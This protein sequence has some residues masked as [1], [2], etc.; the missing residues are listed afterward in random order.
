MLDRLA[1]FLS[2]LCLLHCLLA[3]ALVTLVPVFGWLKPGGESFHFL[4]FFLVFPTSLV[5][6]SAGYRRHRELP[7]PLLGAAG[8]GL[9]VTALATLPVTSVEERVV[10][11]TGGLLLALSHI[12]NYRRCRLA[13]GA[14]TA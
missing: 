13:R 9:I 14:T 2:G 7:I 8:L 1:V 10:T 12:L 11:S 6:L 4:L 3:P 5:A